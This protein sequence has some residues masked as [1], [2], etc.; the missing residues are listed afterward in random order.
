MM[1]THVALVVLV[2]LPGVGKSTVCKNLSS[3]VNGKC[4]GQKVHYIHV[5]YDE[6]IPLSA[7]E[8][9]AQLKQ[10]G[11]E[12]RHSANENWK[13]ARRNVHS[14]VD[15]LVE[16]LKSKNL[17]DFVLNFFNLSNKIIEEEALYVVL[18]DDNFYYRSMRY[19]YFQLA[20]KHTVGF[21]QLYIECTTEIAVQQNLQRETRVPTAV[22]EAMAGKLQ[23]PLPSEH[24]WESATYIL[25]ADNLK[26]SYSTWNMVYKCFAS[27]VLQLEDRELEVAESRLE[28]SRSVA[29]QADIYLRSLVGQVIKES[30]SKGN[31][32]SDELSVLSRT[33]NAGRQSLLADVRS[34]TLLF[35]PNL[36]KV[37]NDS[38]REEFQCILEYEL[39]KRLRE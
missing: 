14:K 23:P 6:L 20:R 25:H 13:T 11:E 17:N 15:Q 34:G 7:Q 30:L 8:R 12:M 4:E 37:V 18:L 36:A 5:C 9:F 19:E 1:E 24:S 10:C 33:V 32:G 3:Y 28:C 38:N 39:R 2:G 35:P 26:E 21:C 29:H 22:I 16:C 31:M 27:P